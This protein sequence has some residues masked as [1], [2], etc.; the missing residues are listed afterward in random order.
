MKRGQIWISA[1]IYIGLGIVAIALLVGAG[2]PLINKMRDRN[3]FFQT[4]D[5]MHT[6]DN[7]IFEV[8]SE[9]PGSRRFLSPVTIRKGDLHLLE[10]LEHRIIWRMETDAVLQE[11]GSKLTEGN[12]EIKFNPDDLIQ[13]QY[14]VE[15]VLDYSDKIFLI[16]NGLEATAPQQLSGKFGLSIENQGVTTL[17]SS[18]RTQIDIKIT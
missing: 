10:N 7:A 11:P 8:L 2:V 16:V 15:L 6:I 1:V 12:L 14:D 13:D 18:G 4:K 17:D 9:G 3:T 5:V